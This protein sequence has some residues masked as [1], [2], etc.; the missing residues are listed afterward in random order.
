MVFTIIA[1]LHA[2]DGVEDQLRAKLAEA[3]QTYS[4]DAS[5]LGYYPM[6]NTSDSRKWTI[7]QRYD[8]ESSVAKHREHPEYKELAGALVPL[9]EGGQ[10]GISVHQF[11]EL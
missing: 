11:N 4:K 3:A 6:Q 8:A 10:E 2:K 5:V 1:S 7:V 9:L